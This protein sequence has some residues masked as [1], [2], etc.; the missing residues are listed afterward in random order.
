MLDTTDLLLQADRNSAQAAP[1]GEAIEK[2]IATNARVAQNQADYQHRFDKLSAEHT[3]L[4]HQHGI[5]LSEITDL[6][7]RLNA[8]QH[9]KLNLAELDTSRIEF[10]P[11]LWHTLTDHAQVTA[12]G[13]V[14]FV[15]RDVSTWH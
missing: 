3:E 6:Q 2:V 15:F 10:T 4:L 9:Y 7:N 11:Y 12:D 14:T 5:I 1:V 13:T 8:Y